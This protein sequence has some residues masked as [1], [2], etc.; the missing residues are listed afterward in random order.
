MSGL[1]K[2]FSRGQTQTDRSGAYLVDDETKYGYME[3]D[4]ELVKQIKK[5]IFDSIASAT[6]KVVTPK[7][8]TK[9]ISYTPTLN[10][11]LRSIVNTEQFERIKGGFIEYLI[12]YINH[13]IINIDDSLKYLHQSVIY[14]NSIS[15][16]SM[17]IYATHEAHKDGNYTFKL[18]ESLKDEQPYNY[19]HPSQGGS[20]KSLYKKTPEKVTLGSQTRVVYTNKNGTK[21]IKQKGDYVLLSKAKKQVK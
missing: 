2:I 18:D 6:M 8:I 1:M 20:K 13:S 14:L 5:D 15:S 21:F 9:Q 12:N 17:F 16:Y 10:E 11:K 19:I 7:I 4:N 3:G